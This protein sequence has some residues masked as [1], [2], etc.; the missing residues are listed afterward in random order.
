MKNGKTQW[1]KNEL[2]IYILLLCA[3]ADKVEREEEVELI[4][5]KVKE[6]DFEKI[7]EEFSEDNEDLALEKIRD[8][9]SKHHFSHRELVELQKE[10]QQVF[11]VDDTF[12]PL[13]RN[14]DRIL[15]NIIY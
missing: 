15:K 8:N 3:N 2:K 10:M 5:S 1:S 9:V 4:R 7:Y 14:L 12:K 11:F 13:E 6:E